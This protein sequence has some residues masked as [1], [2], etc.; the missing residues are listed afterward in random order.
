MKAKPLSLLAVESA[1]RAI[2]EAGVRSPGDIHVE[3]IAAKNGAW[4]VYGPMSTARASIVRADR[5][6]IVWVDERTRGTPW[7]RFTIAHEL[8]H[9]LLHSVEDHFEQCT[10]GEKS[11]G[12]YQVEREANHFSTELLMP[13]ALALPYAN[14]SP[15]PALDEVESFARTF[16]TSLLASALRYVQ[17]TRAPCAVVLSE[18]GRIKWASESASFPGK[19]VQR[20]MLDAASCAAKLGN[21]KTAR[22][23]AGEEREVP[24]SAWG[25]VG[26]YREESIPL[27][28]LP[29]AR[30]AAAIDGGAA[31][32]VLS[33]VVAAD[34]G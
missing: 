6:A 22:R 27:S 20:R 23:L 10:S 5:R 18:A 28:M 31:G 17:L 25:G 30:E 11:G 13:E 26:A 16:G 29:G 34:A 14:R 7:S 21:R 15:A 19:I 24:G 9:H 8:G 3:A 1:R 33:W 12:S 2:A 32:S 4:V